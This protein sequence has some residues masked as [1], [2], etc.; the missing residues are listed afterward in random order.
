MQRLIHDLDHAAHYAELGS[1]YL[2]QGKYVEAEKAYAEAHKRDPEDVDILARYGQTLLRLGRAKEAMPFLQRALNTELK[3]DYG[4]T[5]LAYAEAYQ[6][7]GENDNAI[8]IWEEVLR[9]Y[10]YARARFNRK[11]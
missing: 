10:T 8:Q 5:L 2:Q 9:S 4:Y 3:H 6:A 11:R 1:I 7:L